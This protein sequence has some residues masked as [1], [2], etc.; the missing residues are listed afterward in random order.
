MFW[1][2]ILHKNEIQILYY[3]LLSKKNGGSIASRTEP[4][5]STRLVRIPA[6]W[7]KFLLENGSVLAY[8]M[9]PV[10]F[11]LWCDE[12]GLVLA[13]VMIWVDFCMFMMLCDDFMCWLFCVVEWCCWKEDSCSW[14]FLRFLIFCDFC[15]IWSK[16]LE[17]EK[18]VVF[19]V[20]GC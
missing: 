9:K 8:V 18:R 19:V 17:W 15:G 10:R 20:G 1:K 4:F 11:W 5:K 13:Y 2:K 3:Y 14:M 6:C 12:T 16:V 7:F